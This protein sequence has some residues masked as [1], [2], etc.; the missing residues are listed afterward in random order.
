[1][2]MPDLEYDEEGDLLDGVYDSGEVIE[3]FSDG[4]LHR[5]DG[6]A[7]EYPDGH[8][9]WWCHGKIHREGGPALIWC[10]GD[11]EWWVNGQVHREDGPAVEEDNGH[12]EWWWQDRKLDVCQ[13]N[14]ITKF[15]SDEDVTLLK[16]QYE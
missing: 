14:E 11:K 4:K 8:K 10:D 12:K 16:L 13:W 7:I 1:M 15:Y 6:P 5:D 9:E 2:P 3:Y